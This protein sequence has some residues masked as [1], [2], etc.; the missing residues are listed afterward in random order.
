M[1]QIVR[2]SL[3]LA[4]VAG[5]VTSVA[6]SVVHPAA[7]AP[8]AAPTSSVSAA[9]VTT[10]RVAGPDRYTTAVAISKHQFPAGAKSV[11]LVR[12]DAYADAISAGMVGDG[13]ILLVPGSGQVPSSVLAEVRRLAPSTVYAVGGPA[14]VS[15]AN[16]A[17]AAQGR[18]VK[19]LSGADR[20][21]TAAAVA[22]H[23]Y[24]FA[25][26]SGDHATYV[27]NS[28]PTA[29]AVVAGV[30]ASPYTPV[31]PVPAKGAVPQSIRSV[32]MDTNGGHFMAVGGP[33]SVS[34]A[35]LAAVAA[36]T[37]TTRVGGAD[38]YAVAANLAVRQTRPGGTVYLARGDL[39][40]DALAA[41]SLTRGPLLLVPKSGPM[42][43]SVAQ[44]LKTL[45][46]RQV[47]A[48]GG[49]GSVSDAML[50]TA[51]NAAAGR[52]PTQD[53]RLANP[54]SA[55]NVLRPGWKVVK[56][57]A[58]R[59]ELTCDGPAYS[60]LVAGTYSCGSSAQN[61]H[62]CYAK[63]GH[64]NVITCLVDPWRKEL[65]EY[66]VSGA[67]PRTAGA[68]TATV[69]PLAVA[70]Q[71]GERCLIRMGGAWGWR[72]PDELNPW[73]GC[74]PS[75]D[76]ALFAPFE[77]PLSTWSR[78]DGSTTQYIYGDYEPA[79]PTAWQDATTRYYLG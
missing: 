47:V 79:H 42:P 30:L 65:L 23:S 53:V 57:A 74:L 4:L 32:A 39:F 5:A 73:A 38:R 62:D 48:L 75:P 37:Y 35:T 46:P 21:S 16:L 27:V 76:T 33:A 22:R 26:P 58:S 14:T 63:P 8:A 20:Y 13:P 7:A 44:A 71:D 67:L 70:L 15:A 78:L 18:A 3:R 54:Y 45:A 50:T 77:K 19:R 43:A 69:P 51:K 41:G 11:Y 64:A 2:T 40:T 72:E 49:T 24:R 56:Q 28:T 52:M 17:Q 66:R 34:D 10:S 60:G 29:D 31:L 1:S 55:K 9:A 68:T 25:A 36:G 59:G 12:H 6:A 61:A